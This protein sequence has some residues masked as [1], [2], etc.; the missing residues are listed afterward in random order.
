MQEQDRVDNENSKERVDRP[1]DR[2]EK[3]RGGVTMDSFS[4]P[5]RTRDHGALTFFAAVVTFLCRDQVVSR[6]HVTK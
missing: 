3:K 6:S 5:S 4:R 2:E 1:F